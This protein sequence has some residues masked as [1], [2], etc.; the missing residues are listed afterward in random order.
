VARGAET[1]GEGKEH[2]TS[3]G[4]SPNMYHRASGQRTN[5]VEASNELNGFVMALGCGALSGHCPALC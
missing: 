4:S 5:L 3:V 1:G 2:L